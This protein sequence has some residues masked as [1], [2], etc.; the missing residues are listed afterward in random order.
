MTELK[1]ITCWIVTEG[2]KGTENQ[3]LGVSEALGV[4]AEIKRISLQ[5]PWSILSPWLGFENN[6]I[7]EP[8]LIPPWPDLLIVSGRKSIAAARYIKKKNP[9]TLTVFIQD[10]RIN[11]AAFDLVIAPAHD[12]VKGDNVIKTISA[13]NR[14]KDDKIAIAA[15][16]WPQLTDLPSPRVAVL[17]GGNSKAH[18]LTPAL[19]V[20][21]AKQLKMLSASLMVTVSRRTGTE[22]ERILRKALQGERVF[23]W[24]GEGDNPYFAMLGAADFIIVTNDSASMMSEAATTG[25]PVYAVPLKGGSRRINHMLQNLIDH[26]AVRLFDGALKSWTYKPLS[27]AQLAADAIKSYIKKHEHRT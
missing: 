26:G 3:C 4:Q 19:C 17:I 18:S 12:G 22:N 15:D 6:W 2:L 10:P 1:E 21:L 24:D 14:I 7:F 13:P 16:A 27:D 25:K 5:W 9:S 11:P 20:T 23:F 8:N